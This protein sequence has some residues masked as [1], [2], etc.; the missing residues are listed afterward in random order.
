MGDDKKEGGMKI[1]PTKNTTGLEEEIASTLRKDKNGNYIIR[2]SMLKEGSEYAE[3]YK[4]L[5]LKVNPEKG[6]SNHK[7]SFI[8]QASK[9]SNT[10]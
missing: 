10:E 6:I 3:V 2:K 4:N 1:D 7:L 5:L 9:Q 8:D